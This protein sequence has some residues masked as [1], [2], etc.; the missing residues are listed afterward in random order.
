MNGWD[1]SDMT[2]IEF[3]RMK[4]VTKVELNEFVRADKVD[5]RSHTLEDV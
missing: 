3:G 1:L 4:N 2:G 5:N